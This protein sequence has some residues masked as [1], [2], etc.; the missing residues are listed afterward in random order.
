MRL[1]LTQIGLPMANPLEIK[2]DNQAAIAV[3]TGGDR[4]HKLL[5]HMQIHYHYA[6]DLETE[7]EISVIYV[8]NKDNL[9]DQFTKS[10][11]KDQFKLQSSAPGLYPM[12]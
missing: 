4:P 6:Q 5:K 10:L 9:A 1:F 3:S 11:P 12:S 2:C 7:G 8:P